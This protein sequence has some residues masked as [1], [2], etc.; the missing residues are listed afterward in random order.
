DHLHRNTHLAS[1][2]RETHSTPLGLEIHWR[3]RFRGFHPR[4]M[5]LDL[6]EVSSKYLFDCILVS[7]RPRH[8]E[9]PHPHDL[10]SVGPPASSLGL[11][12]K[13]EGSDPRRDSSPLPGE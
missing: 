13:R 4:L 11:L 8:A 9:T 2:P 12:P 10:Q 3:H 7:K 1:T 6:F 5:T